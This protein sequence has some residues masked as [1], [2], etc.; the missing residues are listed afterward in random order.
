M[1]KVITFSSVTQ[2]SI[3]KKHTLSDTENSST[4]RRVNRSSDRSDQDSVDSSHS[5]QRSDDNVMFDLG[6]NTHGKNCEFWKHY[7]D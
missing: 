1:M 4:V 5:R 2:E 6:G 3:E 7:L